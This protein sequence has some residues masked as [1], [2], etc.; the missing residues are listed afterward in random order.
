MKILPF[1]SNKVTGYSIY[2]ISPENGYT[3][4][5]EAGVGRVMR[6]LRAAQSKRQQN[7][8]KNKYFN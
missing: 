4:K 2:R 7:W 8:Q 1:A 5:E 3:I 6:Q